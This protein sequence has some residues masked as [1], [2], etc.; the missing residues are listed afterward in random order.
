MDKLIDSN[1]QQQIIVSSTLKDAFK[2]LTEDI[3]LWWSK[4][5]E[6]NQKQGGQFTIHFENGYWWTFKI[7][8]FIPYQ[9]IV[10]KCIDGEPDFNKEWIGHILQWK[11]EDHDSKIKINFHQIGLNP[12]IECYDVCTKTWDMFITEKLKSHLE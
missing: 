4:T 5:S 12:D 1:Y 7:L 10:W 9:E 8:K 11:I 6:S 2:A 3:H